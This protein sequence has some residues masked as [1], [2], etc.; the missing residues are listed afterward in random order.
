M[1]ACATFTVADPDIWGHLRF[2][3]DILDAGRVVTTTDRYSFT[4]DRPFM[5]HE[6]LGGVIM[7]LAYRAA[8]PLGM[9]VFKAAVA[10]ALFVLLWTGVRRASP[11][12]QWAGLAVAAAGMLPMLATIRPQTWSALGVVI[13]ARV[14][15]SPSRR[16]LL[17]L[18]PLFA[19]WANL[20]GGWIVGGAILA[21]F[22]LCAF[23]T[24]ERRRW[25]LLLAGAASLAATLATP[26]GVTLWTFLAETVRFSRSDVSEWQPMWRAGADSIVLWGI[27]SALVIA[28]YRRSRLPLAT[29]LVLLFFAVAAAMVDRI[30][31]LYAVTAVTLLGP[32]WPAA[33]VQPASDRARLLI[34]GVA[35]AVAVA[36]LFVSRGPQTCIALSGRFSPDTVVAESLRGTSGRIATFFDWGEYAL[37]HFGPGLQVSLDGR[38]EAIYRD[39][40]LRAQLDIAEGTV[41]GL[42]TLGRMRPDYV[43]LPAWSPTRTW[44]RSNGYRIDITSNR[45]FLATRADL[46]P[47]RPWLGTSS[48]CFP[49][50]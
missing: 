43:W 18:P 22:T 6:W 40:T 46:E 49:G 27:V 2:G 4:A 23:L 30:S 11:A 20:H 41:R 31:P 16:P 5:Y 29:L 32:L 19:L 34:D 14:L 8:G 28:T 10:V 25:M 1:I 45:S 33:R 47:R 39:E 26:Y 15:L 42:T 48:G 13:V 50:P 37:W 17:A 35:A 36:I 12:W 38:R 9:Q 24:W 44:L 3:L 21:I 7:A